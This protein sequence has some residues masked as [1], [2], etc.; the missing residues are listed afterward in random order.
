[1]QLC[2]MEP[3]LSLY[4]QTVALQPLPRGGSALTEYPLYSLPEEAARLAELPAMVTL[5]PD[6]PLDGTYIV[7]PV[8][9]PQSDQVLSSTVLHVI[10]YCLVLHQAGSPRPV[11]GRAPGR[12]GH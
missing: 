12:G 5:Y 3:D 6:G 9:Y 2:E 4:S 7:P 11:R 8:F 10:C 1:M